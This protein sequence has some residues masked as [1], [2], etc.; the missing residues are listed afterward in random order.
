MIPDKKVMRRLGVKRIML[1]IPPLDMGLIVGEFGGVWEIG[2][3]MPPQ[4]LCQIA[5]VSRKKGY[6]VR[7]LDCQILRLTMDEAVKNVASF[8]PDYVGISSTTVSIKNAALFAKKIKDAGPSIVTIIGGAHVSALPVETMG[9]FSG[10]DVGVVGEGE[11]T[12][13]ELIE[14][15]ANRSA[16]SGIPGLVYRETGSIRT[17]APREFIKDLD[18][19]PIPAWD[20]CPALAKNYRTSSQR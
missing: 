1:C 12:F 18:S 17:T 15:L 13:H 9:E 16:L 20:M 4:G 8:E 6:D 2:S 10:F 7:I 19:L 11:L 3:S 14:A 5:A